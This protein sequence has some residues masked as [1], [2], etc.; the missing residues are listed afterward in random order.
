MAR[1]KKDELAQQLD[2]AK[3]SGA[4]M[5]AVWKVQDGKVDLFRLSEKFPFVDIPTA[6]ELLTNDLEPVTLKDQ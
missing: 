4:Y 6:L 5:V 2:K 3:A 1:R